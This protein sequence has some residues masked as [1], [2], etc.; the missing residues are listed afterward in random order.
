MTQNTLV[1]L[2]KLSAMEVIHT[3]FTSGATY[4]LAEYLRRRTEYFVFIEHPFEHLKHLRS[5]MRVYRNGKLVRKLSF[6]KPRAPAVLVF[7]AD[8]L[9]TIRIALTIKGRYD[10]FVGADC[11]NGMA[12]LILKKMKRVKRV[13]F[14]SIDYSPKRFDNPIV[15]RLYH[16]FEVYVGRKSDFV[17]CASNA[18]ARI[19]IENENLPVGKVLVVPPGIQDLKTSLCASYVETYD[20]VYVG[21]L[22]EE[23]GVQ[24]V[25]Y[26]LPTLLQ[27]YPKIRLLIIGTGPFE[28]NMKTLSEKLGIDSKVLFLGYIPNTEQVMNIVSRCKIGLAPYVPNKKYNPFAFPG[29]VIEYM[30]CGLPV[31]TTG[32]HEFAKEVQNR[33]AGLVVEYSVED[34]SKAISNLFDNQRLYEE[35]R[36]NALKLASE[37]KYCEIFDRAF[38][39]MLSGSRSIKLTS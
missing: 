10:I 33:K 9:L 39:K 15:N 7:L 11:L 1:L 13:I 14:Y 6:W 28:E 29:K 20:L 5:S 22:T 16:L 8:L 17:W 18:I 3:L 27:R 38:K 30:A 25:L 26:A 19:R 23:K 12:G 37:F 4:L 24:L 34:L 2:K 32:V 35:L 36:N 31:I 21:V